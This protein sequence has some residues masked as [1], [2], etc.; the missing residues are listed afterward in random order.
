MGFVVRDTEQLLRQL[1]GAPALRAAAAQGLWRRVLRG[2]Y[3]RGGDPA[4]LLVRARAAQ[5]LLPE[6]AYV[7][8][9]SALWLCGLDVQASAAPS[10]EILVPRGAVVPRRIGLEAREGALPTRDRGRIAGVRTLAPQRATL[11]LLRRLPLA[12]GVA[13]ADAVLHAGL[14]SDA[15]LEQELQRHARLRGVRVAAQALELSDARAESLPESRLRVLFVLSGLTPVPQFEV[16]DPAGRVVARVDL[17]FPEQRLAIEYD[18]QEVHTRPD[19]FASDRRR[20]NALVALGWTVLRF[21]A[22]DL[23]RGHGIVAEVR[24]ALRLRAA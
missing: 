18:G 17:A 4:D 7:A 12:D 8:G 10:L 22:T 24:A 2:A 13:V 19:V 20:Q 23:R 21:T 1:G 11:D 5:L 3:V 14:R 15:Q 16:R 6:D 9:R